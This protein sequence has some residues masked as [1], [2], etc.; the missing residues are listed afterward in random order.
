LEV[1]GAIVEKW[2]LV[3]DVLDLKPVLLIETC[4]YDG[5]IEDVW[6]MLIAIDNNVAIAI[7]DEAI[8]YVVF[9]EVVNEGRYFDICPNHAVKRSVTINKRLCN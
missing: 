6:F 9:L 7:D 8:S 2:L 1:A 3:S 5:F 4:T